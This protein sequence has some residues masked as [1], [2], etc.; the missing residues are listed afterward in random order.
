MKTAKTKII[1]L[2]VLMME[3]QQTPVSVS[4]EEASTSEEFETWAKRVTQHPAGYLK[5]A[6]SDWSL[7]IHNLPVPPA[8]FGG[9]PFGTTTPS[10]PNP[11]LQR[12][13]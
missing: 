5:W 2:F 10:F 11:S 6:K 3:E 8:I 4:K 1:Q 7:K 13:T 12:F 9:L